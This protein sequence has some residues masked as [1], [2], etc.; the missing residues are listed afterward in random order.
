MTIKICTS[1]YMLSTPDGVGFA[2]RWFPRIAA[3]AFLQSTK[4][5]V[6]QQA[7]DPVTMIDG[8]LTF[9]N[10]SPDPQ[11]VVVQVLR[12]PRSVVVQNPST[13]TICDAWSFAKGAN[14]TADYPSIIQDTMGGKLQVD[15]ASTTAKD[16]QYG[17]L[18]YDTDTSQEWVDVGELDAGMSMHFR[19][20]ASVQTPGV[21]TTPSEFTPRWEADARWARLLCH[22][23]PLGSK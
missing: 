20:V 17:R 22:V 7:P 4:D 14:P 3:E 23:T 9:F 8:D 18:F 11:M 13:V 19:Y 16:L 1:E 2:K 21:W 5:G 6:I 15:K 10:N 12:A